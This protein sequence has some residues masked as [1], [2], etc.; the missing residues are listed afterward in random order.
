M[1]T[2]KQ[3]LALSAVAY[4]SMPSGVNPNTN[5]K[6][7]ISELIAADL[8][9]GYKDSNGNVN[10]EF[11]ELASLGDYILVNYQ[12]NTSSG[13]SAV[14]FQEAPDGEVV[15]AFRGTEP[16]EI[17]P[18][19]PT[20]FADDF[21][22]D[23][24]IALSGS[25]IGQPNQFK[26]AETFYT[27]TLNSLTSY[28]GY[29]FTGH[30]LGG[31]LA[32]YMTFYTENGGSSVTFNGVGIGQAL[33][34]NTAY[35]TYQ[36]TDYVNENDI[37]GNYGIQL[38]STIYKQDQSGAIIN[39]STINN[40][41][42]YYASDRALSSNGL[43]ISNNVNAS[44]QIYAI[45]KDQ[46][47]A[48]I[49]E[50]FKAHGLSSML[51]DT[52]GGVYDFSANATDSNLQ[53]LTD[54]F[55]TVGTSAEVEGVV[56]VTF[57]LSTGKEIV[58]SYVDGMINV[59]ITVGQAVTNAILYIGDGVAEV[60]YNTGVALGNLLDSTAEGINYVLQHFIG[61]YV[62]INGS[63]EIDNL[64]GSPLKASVIYGL[65][66]SDTI[67]GSPFGDVIDGGAGNDTIKGAYGDDLIYGREGN[68][69]IQG[70][71][72][73]DMIMGGA[74][75]DEL[76]G[77]EYYVDVLGG[78]YRGN[79]NDILDGGAGDDTLIGGAGDD[80]Y[81]FGIGY[82]NDYIS[83]ESGFDTISLLAGIAPANVKLHRRGQYGLELSIV[84]TEDKLTIGDYFYY[85]P[86]E[87][88]IFSDGTIWDEATI[89]EKA[90][91]VNEYSYENLMP[92][93][94]DQNDIIQG[95]AASDVIEAYAGDDLI[96]GGGGDDT[97]Q[98]GEGNDVL[99]GGTGNDTI[100]GDTRYT[101][102]IGEYFTGNGDDTIDGGAGNDT[103]YGGAGNDTYI[104]GL[105]SGEDV[106]IDHGGTDT[107]SFLA[108]IAPEDIKLQRRGDSLE[109]K[110]TSS[111]DKI[112]LS[113]YF[114]DNN[115]VIEKVV[116]ADNTVWDEAT[117]REMARNIDEPTSYDSTVYQGYNNQS[118]I[119]TASNG[120]DTITTG[121]GDDFIDAR[122]GNDNAQGG[123]GNDAIH[124]GAGDDTLYGDIY[125]TNVVG[126]Y[127]TGTGND[128]LD[129]GTG[130]DFLAGGAGND[131]YVFGL[132]YGQD[133]ILDHDGFDTIAFLADVAPEDVKLQ[134]RGDSLE[135]SIIGTDDKITVSGYFSS[136]YTWAIEQV[137]FADS[138]TWNE[139][140][141]REAARYIDEPTSPGGTTYQGYDNQD[142]IIHADSNN[143][144]INTGNG[145]DLI[146]SGAGNDTVIAGNG[147]DVIRGEEGD[148]TLY[149]DRYSYSMSWGEEYSGTGNDT[150]DGGTGNDFLAG[151][152]GND[153]YVFG[154]GYGQD[155]ILEHDGSDT[156]SFLSGVAPED[157]KLQRRGDS[158][159]L[160]IVGTTDRLTISSYFNNS[161]R[162]VESVTFADSTVWN[163]ATLREM[164]RRIDEPS[165]P[166]STTYQ[167][168]DNQDD[169]VQADSNDNTINTG[170]GNDV[171]DAG[172]GNDTVTGGYGN[173]ILVGGD[174]DDSLYGDNYSYSPV[175]G[176]SY[177]GTGD[178]TL[179]GGAGNDTLAGGLGDDVYVFGVGYG[180]DTILDHGG[181][182]AVLFKE[183]VAPE[184]IKVSRVNSTLYLSIIGT[185]DR[186]TIQNYFN[187]SD[188]T[189]A[190]EEI[191]FSDAN[192]TVW[193][194]QDV[195]DKAR[196]IDGT[197]GED[198][199]SG[200][201][202]Q[203]DVINLGDGN[204]TL[205]NAFTGNDIIHAG[206][207]D[208]TVTGGSD[209]DELYG[210]AGNDALYGDYSPNY[211]YVQIGN[212]KL[213][214][215]TGNDQLYG[216]AGDD[217]YVFGRG[218]GQDYIE[219][220]NSQSGS[221]GYLDGGNDTI[222]FKEDVDPTDVIVSRSGNSLIL[223]IVNTD[224][225]LTVQNY[226]TK[227]SDGNYIYAIEN[228]VFSDTNQTVWDIED[229]I[230]KSRYTNGTSGDDWLVGFEDQDDIVN[231]GAGNDTLYNA[232]SGNDIVHGGA[233]DDNITGGNGDDELHG[234]AGN[235][236]L[237]GDY[238]SS[239]SYAQ[240]GN[241]LLDGGEGDDTLYGGA[242]DDTY[243][244]GLGYGNDTVIDRHY[245]YGSSNYLNGGNDTLRFLEGI[246]PEDVEV[247]RS[248]DSLIFSIIGTNDTLTV[249][250]FFTK[251][252]NGDYVYAIENVT[253]SDVN[254]TTWGINDLIDKAQYTNGSSGD[255]W[256]VGFEDQN[257]VINLGAGNDTL[258]NAYA[259]NDV[260][261][262]G[263][264]NDNMTG[265]NG[266]DTL[267]GDAGDDVLYGDHSSSQSYAQTGNDTL[268]GG[269][270]NDTLYGG[271]G[272]DTYVIGLG[273]GNDTIID[274]H[275]Q[276]GGSAYLD[277][278]FDTILF[279]EDIAPE[280]VQ[281]SRSGNSLIF[282]I[283]GT[284]DSLTIS[285]FFTKDSNGEY[286]YAV[287]EVRFSDVNQTVWNLASLVEQA[288]YITGTDNDDWV[289]GYDDQND[290]VSLGDGNDTLYNA[291]AGNDIVHAGAGND[292]ITGGDGNDT[293]YGDTGD[294]TLYG[295]ES[296]SGSYA[297]GADTLDGGTGNDYL[298]GGSGNDTYVFGL[299]YGYDT[300]IDRGRW[301]G[302][303]YVDGGFD[304][305]TFLAGIEP[306]NVKVS[307]SGDS[308]ILSISGTNDVLTVSDFFSKDY[309]GDYVRAIEEVRFADVNETV[310]EF[311]D[312]VE[313]ARFI[314]GTEN[315]DYIY[316][317]DGQLDV[318]HTGGGDDN[319]YNTYAGNDILHLGA[320]NDTAQGGQD[321]DTL[322]GEEGDDVLYGD[323]SSSSSYA[324]GA[325]TLDGGVGNDY[326]YG[327]GGDDTYIF[328]PGYGYDT[329]IDRG[330]WNGSSY[331]DG[332]FDTVVF[333]A[334]IDPEDVTI[335][336]SGSSLVFNFEN[337]TG[338]LTVSDFF[339]KDYNGNYV[340]AI[341]KV[342]FSDTDETVWTF[343]DLIEKARYVYGTNGDDN[344]YGADD[345]SDIIAAG[346]GTDTVY[347]QGGD[348]VITGGTGD[349][350]LYGGYGNDTY[351]FAS[352]DDND[353]ITDESGDDTITFGQDLS[354]IIF[355]Q[356]GSGLQI[357]VAGGADSVTVNSWYSNSNYQ[358]E[359]IE[360]SDGSTISNSQIEQLIQAMATYSSNN[361][362]ISWNDALSS[363][364]Q[365]VQNI[366]AQYWTAPSA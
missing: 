32:Q 120:D 185:N 270:G 37:I 30:S 60:L 215:G 47:N 155:T 195:L 87:R 6:W 301:N 229:V 177:S 249:S 71:Y 222:L 275:Y 235:D 124:G 353:S 89:R 342:E 172:A 76:I 15:F 226:F 269:T 325:D 85:K 161:A 218:Y 230:E 225:T 72:G 63:D 360:A 51:V 248:G 204:D 279:K 117:L 1:V 26:D 160:S 94:N 355:S 337:S 56:F 40:I 66:G 175:W 220:R 241:D 178:D 307:R 257:D 35:S 323:D 320:G 278:G 205:Y 322:Y 70:G 314:D 201:D 54:I 227:D 153:T 288:R 154:L 315:A 200:Y 79:G 252:G 146:E 312:L 237:Y 198:Y 106:V 147:D 144:E 151:G 73:N 50:S 131:T 111:T 247:K 24:Q 19:N 202:N 136:N 81:K 294:D 344:I 182:D 261:H 171:I 183:G 21:I 129:G 143:N 158:L 34:S 64:S 142:D 357:T 219:D 97:I 101:N 128:T 199:L 255:D 29:S 242:G 112:T 213:D 197:S 163:E 11:Y 300:I 267:Y 115:R 331:V 93:Y 208:D 95:T 103:L 141:L 116:F 281:I 42:N 23:A 121:D 102:V 274:R 243:V 80:T 61:D 86:I 130:N 254:E 298:Y 330:R 149:G 260:A 132:G 191:R 291:Y 83:D 166:G 210:E 264:G 283:N 256:V 148:D 122:D 39:Q 335:T 8:I 362:G 109:L 206:A 223:S 251:D 3:Y 127:Y 168:Y 321:N 36:V 12:P 22:A 346:A 305:V 134:R 53:E 13:F 334:G 299:G 187:S 48:L 68:D 173:D 5:E 49:Q 265:G 167:G 46:I 313:K 292:Q 55:L 282:A 152:A 9:Q 340:S 78:H 114:Y 318:V 306:E 88:I 164:A 99:S 303:S 304:T 297:T 7:T 180:Q 232:Y 126:A 18:T 91:Y 194:V 245:Q 33:P 75:N 328:A 188:T 217:T 150:L 100:Y 338:S 16:S 350:T 310:W 123:N 181:A 43:I 162:V 359:T 336:R 196:F 113:G 262:G 138:T 296:S 211:S 324:I 45:Y 192:E 352:G 289:V 4:S 216:G 364:P 240:I 239:Q 286:V 25:V 170:Y 57:V 137:I 366:L 125:Y 347:G 165:S 105:G 250:S 96:N 189:N 309:N 302:S 212:D 2:H 65:M 363:N 41:L 236:I 190:V 234:D 224:D 268:D 356:Y 82:G 214:G 92:G 358:I 207:G 319:V 74:G 259:G 365:D 110:V 27:D 159:E 326:L 28:D 272:D 329:I 156:I 139:A 10:P 107:I 332:G 84:G 184:D 14:A 31:G 345:E 273:Y 246:A 135:F 295:D 351:I 253:F 157:I 193:G 145:N 140:T 228:I 108:G 133:T 238:S 17:S 90:R 119:L 280:N 169:I 176:G 293:L 59:V 349:D 231:L 186:L 287:E 179:D 277:G 104:F 69:A 221:A 271:A 263:D 233:G 290:I 244:F 77:D 316:G 354:S 67:N 317:F 266:D 308:L 284:S 339:S 311:S 333:S 258:Y 203:D 209:N 118:D 98:G 62:V 52:G 44:L 285:E 58:I 327:G 361:N 174:G 341:E 276:Y 38:G 20:G 348:D 343:A